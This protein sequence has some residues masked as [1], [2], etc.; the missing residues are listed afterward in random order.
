MPF[1]S[2]KS[3]QRKI[4]LN[5]VYKILSPFHSVNPFGTPLEETSNTQ[6][7]LDIEMCCSAELQVN[8]TL[9]RES[10]SVSFLYSFLKKFLQVNSDLFMQSEKE[11]F[12]RLLI[13]L[14]DASVAL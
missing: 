8:C 5:L 14:Y 13:L 2:S 7:P 3:I 12:D 6:Y 11:T 1:T 9:F 4:K 10:C